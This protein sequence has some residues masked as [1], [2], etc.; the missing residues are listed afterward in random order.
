MNTI[1]LLVQDKEAGVQNIKRKATIMLFGSIMWLITFLVLTFSTFPYLMSTDKAD[2]EL[3]VVPVMSIVFFGMGIT[4]TAFSGLCM[5]T[6][7]SLERQIDSINI[8]TL[9]KI[10]HS[11]KELL[12]LQDFP[13]TI[14]GG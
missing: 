8:E 4:L 1:N 11:R 14:R 9:K 7:I 5:H 10:Q 6:A 12:A 2:E 3:Q 13:S